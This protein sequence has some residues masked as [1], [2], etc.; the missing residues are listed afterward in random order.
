[1]WKDFLSLFL[2]DNCPLC[3]RPCDGTLCGDCDRTLLTY[4]FRDPFVY[5]REELPLFVWGRYEGKLKQAI[6]RLKYDSQ[7]AIGT[8]LGVAMGRAWNQSHPLPKL[9]LCALIPV[10]LH[11]HRLAAR[12]YNQAQLLG[13]GFS[14]VT[15]IPILPA[16]LVRQR[17]TVALYGLNLVQRQTAM[18]EVFEPGK[19]LKR[20]SRDVS[21]L[22]VDD[23]YTTGTTVKEAATVLK[24]A[25]FKLSGVVAL[26]TGKRSN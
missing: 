1:M 21:I 9:A 7:P 3:Q 15:G 26:S 18:K 2:R 22:L 17:D 8:H 13:A 20:L 6:A 25:G 5:W 24:N 11:P 12:G 4:A 19:D 16:G 23:I 10:P 14:E